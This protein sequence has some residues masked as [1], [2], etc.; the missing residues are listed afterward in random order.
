MPE[1]SEKGWADAYSVLLLPARMELLMHI[2]QL[3]VGDVGIDLR[4]GNVRMAEHLLHAPD[5]G[6]IR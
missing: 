4:R 6:A 3:M 1:D 2:P 5:V